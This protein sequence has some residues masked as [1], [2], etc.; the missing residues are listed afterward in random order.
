MRTPW[1]SSRAAVKRTVEDLPFVRDDAD[2]LEAL[3]RRAKRG[4]QAPHALEPEAHAEQLERE[5]VLRARRRC[6]VVM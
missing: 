4:Q 3:L 6:H 2:R 5:Q 1:A